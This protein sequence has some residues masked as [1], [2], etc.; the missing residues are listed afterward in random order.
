MDDR[1]EIG[2]T[3]SCLTRNVKAY[4]QDF[5]EMPGVYKTKNLR[6]NVVIPMNDATRLKI[7]YGPFPE[8]APRSKWAIKLLNENRPINVQF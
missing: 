1:K 4:L 5:T 6:R 3:V 7:S 2:T 8:F